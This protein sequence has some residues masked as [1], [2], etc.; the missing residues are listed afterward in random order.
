MKKYNPTLYPI[1]ELK[2]KSGIYQIRN[3]VNNKVYIG[4]A[5]DLY[6]RRCQHYSLLK[7][8]KHNHKLQ[9]SYNKYNKENFVFEVIEFIEDTHKLLECEQYWIDR[10]DVTKNGYNVQPIVGRVTITEE[11]K[12]LMSKNH[13]DVSGD[14]NPSARAVVR[15][16]DSKIYTTMKEACKDNNIKYISNMCIACSSSTHKTG[17]YHW[18]YEK[19][20]LEKSKEEILKIINKPNNN[21]KK[22]LCVETGIIYQ[23]IKEAHK[24]TGVGVNIIAQYLVN[25][26]PKHLILTDKFTWSN[27]VDY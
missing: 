4:S 18:L 13:A 6:Q 7:H 1:I 16:E 20:F 15:L 21:C 3:L 27:Y 12:I 24:E 23:S 17:K 9:N 22:V 19:D 14:K 5:L 8:G 2:G 25:K 10:F 11:I 26:R